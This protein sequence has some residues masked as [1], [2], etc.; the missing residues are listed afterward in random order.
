M[1]YGAYTISLSPEYNAETTPAIVSELGKHFAGRNVL[2]TFHLRSSSEAEELDGIK[3]ALA[4]AAFGNPVKIILGDTVT[5]PDFS[6]ITLVKINDSR[7]KPGVEW[8]TGS[9]T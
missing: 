5:M 4:C 1:G 2:F 7:C 3:E 9:S 6:D 8:R